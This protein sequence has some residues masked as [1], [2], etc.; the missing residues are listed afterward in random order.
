[1]GCGTCLA[2]CTKNG[3]ELVNVESEGIRP[4]F[5][6][7]VCS[8]C[9]DCLDVC[10]GCRLDADLVMDGRVKTTEADHEFGQVLELWEG[11]AADPEIRYQASSGGLLSALSIYCLEREGMRFALH[12]GMDPDKPW[13]NRTLQSR[14]RE[15]ILLRCGSRYA[16]ASPCDGLRAIEE[17]EGPCVFIGKPCDTA[18]AGMLRRKRPGL[19]RNLG[20]VLSFC[21]A[22][23]PSTLGTLDLLK[24]LKVETDGIQRLRYRGEGWPGGF[25]VSFSNG[26]QRKFLPYMESWSR[27]TKYVP[28]R[29]RL[30]PDGLGRLSDITCGDAWES[31]RQGS[32]DAG[33][34]I[35]LVRTRRGREILRRASDAGYVKVEPIEARAV[36]A[37]QSN[38]LQ[39]RRQMFGRLLAMRLL[40][41][42]VPRFKGFSLLRSWLCLPFG[43]QV[44]SI[45]G[46]MVRIVQRG[47]W[48]TG[49]RKTP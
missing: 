17:S 4:R 23:T 48:R 3:V 2:A 41:V 39:K 20:L 26:R 14:T 25:D 7:E 27:L 34:S 32:G 12:T 36:L 46:T 13:L 8:N 21:C 15:D 22:G 18:G 47:L 5:R 33:R 37:A 28:L 6:S 43:E 10:P 42:P 30:C 19:D 11:Y 31:Y 24:F 49:G 29:C 9:V 1:M 38:L 45:F 40:L 16:P 44:R 35:I